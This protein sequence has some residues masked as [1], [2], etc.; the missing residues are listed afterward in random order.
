MILWTVIPALK[1][2][3]CAVIAGSVETLKVPYNFQ[4][5]QKPVYNIVYVMY[6]TKCSINNMTKEKRA[7]YGSTTTATTQ[8]N[9]G[10]GGELYL[11]FNSMSKRVR[12]HAKYRVIKIKW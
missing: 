8:T 5:N 11:F 12:N 2:E 3:L 9:Q 6:C 1:M 7:F 4:T 10:L